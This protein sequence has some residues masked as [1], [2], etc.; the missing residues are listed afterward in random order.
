MMCMCVDA[1]VNM[2]VCVCVSGKK[3]IQ[4]SLFV[5]GV[6]WCKLASR[7]NFLRK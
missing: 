1:C 7:F 4:W 2:C 6:C 3:E 5:S